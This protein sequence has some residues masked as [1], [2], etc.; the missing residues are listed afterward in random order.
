[1]SV[2]FVGLVV[3]GLLFAIYYLNVSMS[4]VVI[5]GDAVAG[6][7][8]V[9]VSGGA[10]TITIDSPT[11]TTYEFDKG[12]PYLINLNVSADYF[13]DDWK[14]YLYDSR[15]EIYNASG[16][17]VVA[18]NDFNITSS[19]NAVRWGNNFTISVHEKD[20]DWTNQSVVFDVEVDGSSPVLG[21][22]NDSIF[23]CEDTEL[24]YRFNATDVDEDVLTPT[25]SSPDPIFVKFLSNYSYTVR[26]FKIHSGVLSVA[27]GASQFYQKTVSVNDGVTGSDSEVVNITVIAVNDVPVIESVGAQTI[28]LTSNDLTFY[29]A[30]VV[31][32]EEDGVSA[33]GNMVFNLTWLVGDALF[34]IDSSTG[35]MDYTA[36]AGDDER[37]YSLRVCVVDNALASS[38]ENISLCSVGAAAQTV[39]DDF[40]LSVNNNNQAP[41][42]DVYSPSAED[43]SVGGT[44]ATVF[45]VQVSDADGGNPNVYWY[46]DGVLVESNSGVASDSYSYTLGCGL[47]GSHNVS[48]NV[49]D[50]LESVVR[51]WDLEVI[52]VACPVAVAGAGGGGGSGGGVLYCYEDWVCGDWGVCQNAKR[53]LA[54]GSLSPEDY[55]FTE[56]VC[57]QNNYD[58]RVCGFQLTSCRDLKECGNRV[59][60]AVKP[61]EN[62]V[63]Y[64][65]ENPSC[66]DGYTNCHSGG[67]ELLVDCGGPC[68]ACPSCSDGVHNQGEENVDCGGPCPFVC[69]VE[70]PFSF[71]ST[72]VLIG[73][74]VWA[75]AVLVF[76][77][78]KVIQILKHKGALKGRRKR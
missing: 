18:D 14:Y 3:V 25:I 44:T 66:S 21:G 41:T 70:K 48:V 10:K 40:S 53:S 2:L 27:S 43:I 22:I 26:L 33:D 28:D 55:Q 12:V 51:T 36:S 74:S 45:S 20:G 54:A 19:F 24:D 1:M 56:G 72:K 5:T 42:I 46:V 59:P 69:E 57:L 75:V 37:V 23:V 58:E 49:S 63:C 76:I 62:R 67:C 15:H 77:L 17:S 38:H 47:S 11:A 9:Y 7:V 13:V 35:V 78:V 29:H 71:G 73:L 65:T 31:T 34:D 16:V 61:A 50:G 30:V 52:S 8:Q 68:S 64:F 6:T 4:S 32:D 60:Y 39:C